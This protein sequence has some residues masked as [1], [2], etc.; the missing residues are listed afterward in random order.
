MFLAPCYPLKAPTLKGGKDIVTMSV[1]LNLTLLGSTVMLY[2]K[3]IVFNKNILI[4]YFLNNETTHEENLL[5]IVNQ[6]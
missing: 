4:N 3:N 2:N 6:P 5:Q 1:H